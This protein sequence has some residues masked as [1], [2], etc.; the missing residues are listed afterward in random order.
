MEKLKYNL[1]KKENLFLLFLIFFFKV[2]IIY[3]NI[4]KLKGI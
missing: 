1:F 2:I 4:L 3:L